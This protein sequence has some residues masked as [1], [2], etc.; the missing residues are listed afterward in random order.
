MAARNNINPEQLALFYTATDLQKM[1]TRSVD[2][3]LSPMGGFESM[4]ELW[5][6]KLK[7]SKKSSPHAHGGGVYDSIKEKGYVG[8]KLVV[9]HVD[10]DDKQISNGHHR[11]AAAAQIEKETNKPIFIPVEHVETSHRDAI[12][13]PSASRLDAWRQRQREKR[14]RA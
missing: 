2:R 14:G 8:D 10:A 13:V 3:D 7:E 6:R 12:N 5:D 4:E 11:I 1:L 9:V